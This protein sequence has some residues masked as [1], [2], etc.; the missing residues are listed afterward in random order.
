MADINTHEI[1]IAMTVQQANALLTALGTLPYG[2]AASLISLIHPQAQS[3][4]DE[5]LAA[6]SPPAE[7]KAA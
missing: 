1:K 7:D 2:T 5:Y 3:Q 6:N 4:V